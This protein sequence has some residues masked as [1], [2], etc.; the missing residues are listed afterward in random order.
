MDILIVLQAGVATGTALLFATL[1]ELLAERSGIMNLGVE[2]MM[3][4]GAMAGLLGI[5]A[6]WGTLGGRHC[7]YDRCGIDQPDPRIYYHSSAGGSG[8]KRSFIK[9]FGCRCKCC[10]W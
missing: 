5:C 2:G 7:R 9:L 3:L 10:S 4:L 1:G 8:C 6:L